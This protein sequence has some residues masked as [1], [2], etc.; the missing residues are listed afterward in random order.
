MRIIILLSVA[1]NLFSCVTWVRQDTSDQITQGMVGGIIET[2][3]S[4]KI[5]YSNNPKRFES[6]SDFFI[7]P[8]TQQNLPNNTYLLEKCP[9]GTR[10][11]VIRFIKERD[12]S[13]HIWSYV[14]FEMDDPRLRQKYRILRMIGLRGEADGTPWGKEGDFRVV[15]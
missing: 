14:E 7:V 12:S 15:R 5:C 3:N 2:K 6:D 1:A 10:G 4:S 11:R 13:Q 9:S 8:S